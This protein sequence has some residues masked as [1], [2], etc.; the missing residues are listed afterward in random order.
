MNKLYYFSHKADP[1]INTVCKAVGVS[2]NL[3]LSTVS[4]RV[5]NAVHGDYAKEAFREEG[6]VVVEEL[7]K[8]I[9]IC[10][11]SVGRAK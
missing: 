8:M 10:G 9:Q 2:M 3:P 11:V 5:V 4:C 7:I 1:L 6:L